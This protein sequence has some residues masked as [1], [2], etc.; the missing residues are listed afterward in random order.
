MP[1]RASLKAFLRRDL[2]SRRTRALIPY[3]DDYNA[4]RKPRI[5]LGYEPA[6]NFPFP[7]RAGT[8]EDDAE[9]SPHDLEPQS[10]T[11]DIDSLFGEPIHTKEEIHQQKLEQLLADDRK[12]KDKEEVRPRIQNPELLKLT[13]ELNALVSRELDIYGEERKVIRG[14]KLALIKEI[15][16][17]ETKIKIKKVED[18]KGTSYYVKSFETSKNLAWIL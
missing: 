3:Y 10:P 4:S 11:Q 9:M 5:N 1:A 14:Q 13:G 15:D 8:P 12:R 2:L 6:A 16:K 17:L 7:P 18:C